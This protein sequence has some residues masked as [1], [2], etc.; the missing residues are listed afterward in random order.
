[1]GKTDDLQEFGIS[2]LD[3]Q[4]S[5]GP[6]GLLNLSNLPFPH[7]LSGGLVPSHLRELF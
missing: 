4:S 2:W 6:D 7:L 1:M 3:T 5:L